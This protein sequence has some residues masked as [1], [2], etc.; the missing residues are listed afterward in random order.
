MKKLEYSILE[1][2]Q[3]A[4][5]S[6]RTLRYYHQIGLLYPSRTSEA[7]YRFYEDAQVDTLQQILFYREMG[8][9]LADIKKALRDEGFSWE[10]ALQSHLQELLKRRE[11]LDLLIE[12]VAKTIDYRKGLRTMT[13][14]EKFQGF[15]K[16][17]IAENEKKYGEEIR[18][19]YGEEAVEKSNDKLMGLDQ[20]TFARME[21]TARE[22]QAILEQSVEE[23]ISPKGESGQKAAALHRD[24]LAYTWPSYSKEAHAGLVQMYTADER[25]K[26]YYDSRVKGC[27]QFLKE[28]VEYYCRS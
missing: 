20:E 8:L 11:Q 12:N 21:E 23:G 10:T 5:V 7:G 6:T 25:F 2:A 3:M 4:G 22:I 19:K 15:K 1:L 13:D 27:A 18:E 26:S 14:Q 16:D 24:W 9:K 17:L 28:A